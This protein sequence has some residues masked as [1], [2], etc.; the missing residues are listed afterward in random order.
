[1]RMILYIITDRYSVTYA[2]QFS[3]R[4]MTCRHHMLVVII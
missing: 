2:R 1:M 3:L 4:V